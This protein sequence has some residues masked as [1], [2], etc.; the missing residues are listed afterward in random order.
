MTNWSTPE[1]FAR[2]KHEPSFPVHAMR[3]CLEHADCTLSDIDYVVYYE[4]PLL[5]F[6]RL[7]ETYVAYAPAGFA[8]FRHAMPVWISRPKTSGRR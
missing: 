3:F 6:E 8:S 7:L 1:R 4:K 5:K 2:V